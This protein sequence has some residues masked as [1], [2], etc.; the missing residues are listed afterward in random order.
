MLDYGCG[1]ELCTPHAPEQKG[2]VENL[3]GFVKRA[4]FTAR[5]F[6]DLEHDLPQ[7]LT[8]WLAY[9]NTER[10]SRATGVP[11]VARLATEQARS[12]ALAI[13]PDDYGLHVPVTVGP[14]QVIRIAT[15]NAAKALKRQHEFGSIA[16][17]LRADVV[18]LAKDP[19]V[20]IANTRSIEQVVQKGQVVF[21][22]K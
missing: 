11:P 13:A 1:I 3:V 5:R 2:S 21:S 16:P 12:H 20:D 17:G 19:L 15:Y 6:Q 8:A 18:L 4:F 7:Q 14:I 22:A 9:A 10:P